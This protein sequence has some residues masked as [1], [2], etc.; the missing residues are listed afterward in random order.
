M[1][2]RFAGVKMNRNRIVTARN[3]IYKDKFLDLLPV[4]E[5]IEKKASVLEPQ[6]SPQLGDT[7]NIAQIIHEKKANSIFNRL[8]VSPYHEVDNSSRLAKEAERVFGAKAVEFVRSKLAELNLPKT[9]N[10]R[11]K[12]I[13]NAQTKTVGLFK[14]NEVVAYGDIVIELSHP[15][16]GDKTASIE[17]SCDANTRVITSGF[18][19]DKKQFPV[20]KDGWDAMV[21]YSKDC[22]SSIE[23]VHLVVRKY[24]RKFPE[25]YYESLGSFSNDAAIEGM[26]RANGLIVT[27]VHAPGIGR[28]IEPLIFDES[29]AAKVIKISKALSKTSGGNVTVIAEG[30]DKKEVVKKIVDKIES[31]P[32]RDDLSISE[33]GSD[34][35]AITGKKD[36]VLGNKGSQHLDSASIS[37]I[38]AAIVYKLMQE[39]GR[40]LGSEQDYDKVRSFLTDL[41]EDVLL[42]YVRDLGQEISGEDLPEFVST[43]YTESKQNLLQFLN[44][45]P[46][47]FED[48]VSGQ[49]E[50]EEEDIYGDSGDLDEPY[51]GVQYSQ[52]DGGYKVAQRG[53]PFSSGSNP[54]PTKNAGPSATKAVMRGPAKDQKFSP[55]K[56]SDPGVKTKG[57]PTQTDTESITAKYSPSTSMST[58]T[59]NAGPSATKA[60]MTGPAGDQKMWANE[61]P[62][63]VGLPEGSGSVEEF[64][65]RDKAEQKGNVSQY[66]ESSGERSVGSKA[67]KLEM[68][69][70]SGKG[71][72]T[73][74][75]EFIERKS[76]IAD[77]PYPF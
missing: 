47:T 25:G 24:S 36:T 16:L 70:Y 1:N 60:K 6:S 43:V 18:R 4:D 41:V 59:K 10:V 40:K 64:L 51:T 68:G 65:T 45:A 33:T 26:L 19:M 71:S 27:R 9:I 67:M 30:P 20:T 48:I 5:V 37:D 58:P 13:K 53:V 75:P 14:K 42:N 31:S 63:S 35:V 7:K 15:S 55:N 23:P 32:D 61:E 50:V 69:Q 49:A 38:E 12:A 73:S 39:Y 2:L 57:T 74:G 76:S 46:D 22:R 77:F 8:D 11:V 3:S 34:Q 72:L 21:E 52:L 28:A 17:V 56:F 62:E 54:E 29:D 44:K 66:L